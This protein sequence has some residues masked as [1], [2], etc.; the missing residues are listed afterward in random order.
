MR[1]L[2]LDRRVA[3]QLGHRDQAEERQQQL[4]ERGHRAVREDHRPGRVEADGQV[5][6]E[7]PGHVLIQP[8][9]RVPVGQH[10]EIGDQHED[11]GA[12]IL[13]PDPVP[14]RAEVVAQVQR[15]R[16]P[17]AGQDAER[18]RVLVDQFLEFGRTPVL[19]G[20]GH[21]YRPPVGPDGSTKKAVH[22]DGPC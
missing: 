11:L 18:R 22:P 17:V 1:D 5:V 20:H 13:Q 15:P 6:E 9:G 3:V 4:V 7:Y 10:L 21:D 12:E 14:Q 19:D 2:V 16:R 8:F